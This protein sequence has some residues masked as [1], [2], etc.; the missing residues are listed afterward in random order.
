MNISLPDN[1]K[2]FVDTQVEQGGYSTSSE[3]IRDLIREDRRRKLEQH[4]NSL[5]VEGLESG[6][7]V[8][9]DEAFWDARKREILAES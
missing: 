8:L 3:Y 6:E 9:A 5:L 4:L 7:P 2:G 1:L